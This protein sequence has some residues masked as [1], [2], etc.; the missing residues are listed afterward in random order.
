MFIT[1][2]L[3]AKRRRAEK[4][5]PGADV[6]LRQLN[7]EDP[8]TRK[9]VGLVAT[10]GAPPRAGAKVVDKASGAQVGVVTSGC[11]SPS[12][13]V[14]VAMAYVKPDVAK[15][16]TELEVEGRG[17]RKVAVT[18]TKMPFVRANYYNAK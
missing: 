15:A 14:N 18:V 7:K 4:N 8:V 13:G 11:P 9:R 10:Q 12:L 17:G 3:I 5:F 1:L 6:I 2:Y 16:K